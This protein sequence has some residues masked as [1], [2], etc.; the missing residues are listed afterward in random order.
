MQSDLIVSL[1]KPHE[2]QRQILQEAKRFNVV[3]NGRRWGKSILSIRLTKPT[4]IEPKLLGFWTP[5]YKDLSETWRELK[6]R[7]HPII[8]RKDEQLKK[9]ELI[10]GSRID[11]WSMEDPDS[12]RGFKYHRAIIDEFAKARNG[13]YA[14][15]K[16]IRATLT[17]YK[18]DAWFLS[19]PKG[20]NGY[21]FELFQQEK[22]I[23]NWKSWQMPTITNP[24]I[25]PS[26][27]ADAERMLDPM[28]FKQEFLAEF[29]STAEKPFMYCFDEK[30]HISERAVYRPGYT[31]YLSFD[32]NVNPM[33][34]EIIQKGVDN[35]KPWIHFIGEI[36]LFNSDIDEVCRHINT[37][38]P[39]GHFMVTGDRSGQN[40]TGL[41][42]NINYYKKIKENL[43]LK[44]AQFKIPPNPFY[45]TNIVLC[46]SLLANHPEILF[47]PVNCKETIYDMRFVQ[48]DGEKP[49]KEDRTKREQRADLF[50]CVRYY[51]NTFEHGFIK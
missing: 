16:T 15:E 21:F 14:W 41:N 17:D 39:N 5:T 40:R 50:D 44:D 47:H 27:V 28:T 25:D 43:N 18:G 1:P 34:C 36:A 42:K 46:N 11:M 7:L 35:G 13:Q 38:F 19:T 31:I 20:I 12:G 26:E 29:I 2:K 48:W 24:Y 23:D 37:R 10:N 51:F 4:I 3:C 49:I 33:T 6:F 22:Q 30:K 9:I 8:S 32:F 45:E